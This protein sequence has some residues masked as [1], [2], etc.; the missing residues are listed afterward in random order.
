MTTGIQDGAEHV[1][2]ELRAGKR[3]L[4]QSTRPVHL[5]RQ[6]LDRPQKAASRSRRQVESEI[7]IDDLCDRLPEQ[8]GQVGLQAGAR[9]L[10][11][12]LL[13]VSGPANAVGLDR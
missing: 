9:D 8:V 3:H 10:Q 7:E 11:V 13:G 4:G 1:G 5:G 2:F 12:Q 6:E